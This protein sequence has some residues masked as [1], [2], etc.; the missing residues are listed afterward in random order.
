MIYDSPLP[1]E[2]MTP[3]ELAAQIRVCAPATALRHVSTDKMRQWYHWMPGVLFRFGRFQFSGESARVYEG[4]LTTEKTLFLLI[5]H[6]V[7]Q[8]HRRT[9]L[10][11]LARKQGITSQAALRTYCKQAERQLTVKADL[12][13]CDPAVLNVGHEVQRVDYWARFLAYRQEESAPDWRW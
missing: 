10:L 4:G 5:P 2:E 6:N 1:S 8:Q 13:L 3:H 11:Q 7:H 9:L 12:Y